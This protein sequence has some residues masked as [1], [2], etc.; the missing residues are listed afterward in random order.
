MSLAFH[1]NQSLETLQP[2]K[3]G[4]LFYVCMCVRL[5]LNMPTLIINDFVLTGC[6]V[7]RDCYNDGEGM[8]AD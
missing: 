7:I 3:C 6:K 4:V 8:Q 2:L 5:S 1:A